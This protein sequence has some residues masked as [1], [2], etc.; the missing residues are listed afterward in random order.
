[1]SQKRICAICLERVCDKNVEWL[2]CCHPFHKACIDKW[3]EKKH[4]CPT[5]RKNPFPSLADESV[6]FRF[7]T[8]WLD[9]EPLEAEVYD[10]E[11]DDSISNYYASEESHIHI[12]FEPSQIEEGAR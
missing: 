6:L 12:T 2:P 9:D 3:L 11:G 5:C 8:A 10:D 4:S 1:M 7:V